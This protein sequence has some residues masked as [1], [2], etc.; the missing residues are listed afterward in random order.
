MNRPVF[1]MGCVLLQLCFLCASAAPGKVVYVDDDATGTSDGSSWANAFKYL[2]DALTS[3]SSSL[4]SRRMSGDGAPVAVETKVE[5]EI[6]VAQGTYTPDQSVP[7]GPS[8][9]PKQSA[10]AEMAFGLR[11]GM[12]I[13][14]GY[15]GVGAP[16]PDARDVELYRTMLSGDLNGDDIEVEHPYDL[17]RESTRA[18]NSHCI[19]RSSYN[20]D[21][22]AVLDGCILTGATRGAMQN[23]DGSPTISNCVFAWNATHLYG[24]AVYSQRGKLTL[25]RCR[26]IANWASQFGGAVAGEKVDITMTGCTFERNAAER[27]GAIHC[28][29]GT[30]LASDCTFS[31]NATP[32]LFTQ[33]SEGGAI[34]LFGDADATIANC[35]FERNS[36][37]RGGAIYRE[38]SHRGVILRDCIFSGNSAGRGGALFGLYGSAVTNCIFAGNQAGWGGAVDS[39][40]SGPEFVNC[41]F[42]AN[43]ADNGNA[44]ARYSCRMS[45][46]QPIIMTN[47]ILWDDGNEVGTARNTYPV[48]F[49]KTDIRFSDVFDGWP[50]EGN[51]KVDP[52]FADPGHW[53]ANGTPDDPNDDIWVH[54]D[55]HLKSQAGRW[56]PA[57][58]SWVLDE[59]T[60][61]CINAGDPN[62][63]VG[64][65]PEPNGGRIN[66]GTYGGTAEA[67]KSYSGEH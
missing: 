64:D 67:S 31:G 15:A 6:R 19:V 24:G 1:T 46:E 60:S 13:K 34:G 37:P 9:R 8:A 25:T 40:C 61:P 56:D 45:P 32:L 50:G 57:T 11:S 12:S 47:C 36:A 16:D 10:A 20:T 66:M 17:P 41:T 49:L 3:A 44:M 33:A 27:Q 59:V 39:D 14:G 23:H 5:V 21:A 7:S 52:Y 55:Y 30:L 28:M 2:Q 38:Y 22:T 35:L 51:I 26:F 18:E 4:P 54:G 65:E 42:V 48:R 58:E 53:D 63:P 29:E 43:R 62:S